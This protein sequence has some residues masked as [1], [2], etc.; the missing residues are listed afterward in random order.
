MYSK[1][2][3]IRQQDV[4]YDNTSRDAIPKRGYY[5][6]LVSD[7]TKDDP[8]KGI[9]AK[10]RMKL[11]LQVGCHVSFIYVSFEA[12]AQN[13]FHTTGEHFADTFSNIVMYL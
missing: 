13:R 11:I 7:M 3:K 12:S 2:K 9:C 1:K 5:S 6:E 8:T 4:V 10:K